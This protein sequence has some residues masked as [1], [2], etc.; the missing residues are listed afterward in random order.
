MAPNKKAKKGPA[1][2]WIILANG[3][4]VGRPCHTIDDCRQVVAARIADGR[5]DKGDVH[6][7]VR[8]ARDLRTATTL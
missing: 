2:L 3:E 6:E 5:Y 1:A 4:P 7:A 8:Y